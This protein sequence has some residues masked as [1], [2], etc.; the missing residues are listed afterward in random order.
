MNTLINAVVRIEQGKPI[1]FWYE[2]GVMMGCYNDKEMHCEATRQY[3]YSLPIA[4]D[5]IAQQYIKQ[6]ND[7]SERWEV[8]LFL[9]L[10]KRLKY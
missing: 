7:D 6:Y 2:H 3:M 5:D 4:Q 9:K 10:C 1:I 8:D